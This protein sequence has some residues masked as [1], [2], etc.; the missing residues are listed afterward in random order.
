MEGFLFFFRLYNKVNKKMNDRKIEILLTRLLNDDL[1]ES[2][3][4]MLLKWLETNEN[5]EYFKQ[6]IATNTLINHKIQI[7]EDKAFEAFLTKIQVKQKVKYLSF[8]KYASVALVLFGLV[9]FY[10]TPDFLSK[11]NNSTILKTNEVTLTLDNGEIRYLDTNTEAQSV[12]LSEQI[13]AVASSNKIVYPSTGYSN[14]DQYNTLSVPYGKSFQ[15]VLSDGTS[16]HLNSGSVFK[17]PVTFETGQE[18]NVYLLDGEAYLDVIKNSESP[19]KVNSAL[20]DVEV[21][22][23][24][25][26]VSAY[27]DDDTAEVVLVEGSVK[28]N[29]LSGISEH[30]SVYLFPGDK[31]SLY[32]SKNTFVIEKVDTESYIS[33]INGKIVFKNTRLNTILKKLERKYNITIVNQNKTLGDEVFTA[34]FQNETIKEVMEAFGRFYNIDYSLTGDTLIIY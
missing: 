17:Y 33:W 3:I 29:K 5:K 7:D 1:S 9:Q 31:A 4:E 20:L 22:G 6:L 23:T 14:S 25:F 21:L 30:D 24:K 26:N 8:L 34:S 10:L 11:S 27:Q 2:E 13:S 28:L 12:N 18:R 15:V 32:P 16:V 19:F